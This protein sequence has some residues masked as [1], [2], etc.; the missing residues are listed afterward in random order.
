MS[1][2]GAPFGA[3]PRPK[4]RQGKASKRNAKK[5][6]CNRDLGL[7]PGEKYFGLLRAQAHQ[8]QAGLKGRLPRVLSPRSSRI[9]KTNPKLGVT[10]P[11][12]TSPTFR[13]F[14]TRGGLRDEQ[15]GEGKPSAVVLA[16]GSSSADPLWQQLGQEG[17]AEPRK[18]QRKVLEL[19]NEGVGSS[20][21]GLWE[22]WI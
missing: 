10:F 14:S 5:L 11:L 16:P 8:I 13:G 21:R 1:A 6:G 12:Q 9:S 4:S 20:E 15:M 2:L 17:T 7:F 19:G 18:S 22:T 3:S